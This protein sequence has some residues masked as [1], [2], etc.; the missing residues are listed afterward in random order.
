MIDNLPEAAASAT[1]KVKT[2][3]GFEWLFTMRDNAVS[4]LV[5]KIKTIEKVF[6]TEGWQSGSITTRKQLTL[7]LNKMDQTCDICGAPAGCRSGT[8]K[9]TGNP[10]KAVFCSV[11]ES[12][13]KWIS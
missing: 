11:D 7:P 4:D 2:P 13:T 12:H 5:K 9:K 3:K 6:E 1:V 8:S 10:W